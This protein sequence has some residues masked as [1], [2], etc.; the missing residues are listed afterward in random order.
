MDI[1]MIYSFGRASLFCGWEANGKPKVEDQP[2]YREPWHPP[3]QLSSKAPVYNNR[4]KADEIA[5]KVN[6]ALDDV[7]RFRDFYQVVR[8]RADHL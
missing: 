1:Y 2:L 6:H 7:V 5:M 8:V 4:L 3:L